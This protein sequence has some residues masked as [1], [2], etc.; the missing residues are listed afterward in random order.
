M[1]H[2]ITW[3][4]SIS[5]YFGIALGDQTSE[6]DNLI[7]PVAPL[8]SD[9]TGPVLPFATKEYILTGHNRW[10]ISEIFISRTVS[11]KCTRQVCFRSRELSP[12]MV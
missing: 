12:L 1:R 9:T 10:Q 3:L 2:T 7:R 6:S 4:L 8:E 5:I 11:L